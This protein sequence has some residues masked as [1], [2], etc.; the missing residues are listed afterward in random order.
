[1][2]LPN[3]RNQE[4]SGGI[5]LRIVALL[6][7]ALATALLLS[8]VVGG[9]TAQVVFGALAT[10]FPVVLIGIGVLRRGRLGSTASVLVGLA[11]LLQGGYWGML[12]LA[13]R[14]LEG[15]WLAGLPLAS[16]LL[17][18]TFWIG[19][20]ILVSL[21]YALTFRHHGVDEADLRRLRAVASVRDDVESARS[22]G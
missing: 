14:A 8:M 9:R 22:R 16:A 17:L 3:D 13:G 21:G 20:L 15:P 5:T 4:T 2:S 6:I 12:G 19:P 1:M 7:A 18:G 11:I 10:L